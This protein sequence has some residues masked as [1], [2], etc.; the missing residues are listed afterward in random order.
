MDPSRNFTN[1]SNQDSP[2]QK[3]ESSGQISPPTPQSQFQFTSP[4]FMHNFNP[5]GP[6][7][8]QPPYGHSPPRFQG[9][10]IQHQGSWLQH[11]P[12]SFQ[13]FHLQESS[14]PSMT[15]QSEAAANRSPSVLQFSQS[16]GAA[17]NSS[18]HGSESSSQCPARKEKEP[19]IIEESSSSRPPSSPQASQ[20]QSSPMPV[21]VVDASVPRSEAIPNRTATK[22][23]QIWRGPC[24]AIEAKINGR[25]GGASSSN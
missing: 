13:G 9:V 25:N 8:N 5:F 16:A 21:A 17:A 18:S 15:M 7:V 20:S 24:E 4:N 22:H 23:T 19:L 14:G 10:Q 3:Y 2:N 1:F 6:S 11:T 12:P